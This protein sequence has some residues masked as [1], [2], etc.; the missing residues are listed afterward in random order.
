MRS[1]ETLILLSALLVATLSWLPLPAAVAQ[2]ADG[3]KPSRL[4]S[5]V[6]ASISPGDDFF[7]YAN[8]GW[9]KATALPAGKER[10]G[11][12]DELEDLTRRRIAA[13][14]DA[15]S[16]APAGSAARKVADFHAAYLNAAAVEAR[17]LASL[18]PLLDRIEQVSDK[19]ELTRLLG[20]S[21]RADVDPLGFGI[22]KSAGVLGLS[23]GQSIHGE[24]TNSAFLVQGGLGLPDRDDYLSADPGKVALRARY[25]EYIRKMLTLAGLPRVDARASRGAD[26]GNGDRAKPGHA[27]GVGQR[28]Q[29]RQR[30]DAC[31]LRASGP[32]GWTGPRSSTRRGCPGRKSS[33]CGSRPP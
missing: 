28:P 22:Y 7:A 30:V 12:R 10:W 15:A 14:L 2:A 33:S 31:R 16:A 25:R 9:L 27:R 17:G 4:E 23:V 20:R 13:L 18:Q 24:K 11:A 19:A 3:R 5:T 8:G 29:C 26:A 1:D 32:R 6:D 21:M